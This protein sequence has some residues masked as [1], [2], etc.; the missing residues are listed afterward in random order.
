MVKH[1]RRALP[2]RLGFDTIP[3]APEEP[4]RLLPRHLKLRY[5]VEIRPEK[6]GQR[7]G[8]R[9]SVINTRPRRSRAPLRA[10]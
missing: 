1:V 7:G 2:K 8:D 5:W 9:W 4:R 10:A 3:L 6:Q